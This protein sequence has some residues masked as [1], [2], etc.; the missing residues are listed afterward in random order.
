M[1]KRSD[2]VRGTVSEVDLVVSRSNALALKGRSE[3]ARTL[4]AT[5]STGLSGVNTAGGGGG[6]GTAGVRDLSKSALV[7]TLARSDGLCI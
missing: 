1:K 3:S 2:L 6:N 5:T 7:N 4:N